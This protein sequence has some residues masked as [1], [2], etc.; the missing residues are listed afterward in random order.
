MHEGRLSLSSDD[1]VS[2][3]IEVD[4]VRNW[5]DLH[6]AYR[7]LITRYPDTYTETRVYDAIMREGT[8]RRATNMLVAMFPLTRYGPN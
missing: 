7:E 2:V 4:L 8:V 5:A 6:E 1:P 3:V